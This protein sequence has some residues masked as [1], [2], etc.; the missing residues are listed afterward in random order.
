M[1]RLDSES[2]LIGTLHVFVAFDWGEEVDLVK[3]R[4][5]VTAEYEVLA[6]R[7]RTPSSIAYRPAPLRFALGHLPIQ[8]P[9]IGSL[10]AEVDATLFD[11]AAISAA[12]KIPFRLTPAQLTRVAAWLADPA[13]FC[14]LLRS[15]LTPLYQQLKPAIVKHEWREEIS[16]EYLVFEFPLNPQMRPEPLL[17]FE[18]PWL[19]SLVTLESTP[20][21]GEEI[22]DA[23]RL[24]ISYSPDDLLLADWGAAV[25]VDEN[26]EETLQVIELSNMQLLEYRHLD[27]RLD[28]ILADAY[29]HTTP[30]SHLW[31]MP[32]RMFHRPLRKLG[33]LKVDANEVFER[34]GNVLKLVGDQYLARAYRQLA[35]RF[36][37]KEWEQSIHRKLD[38]I[39]SIYRTLSDQAAT[40]RAELME[41]IIIILIVIEVLNT[42]WGKH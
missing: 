15:A 24:H 19:A 5:L 8:L 3:A 40:S 10:L 20:L 41:L 42:F 32:W 28:D 6:R 37:L 27:N 30:S 22:D 9:E 29:K 17:A 21:S 34:T 35:K 12:L 14:L 26:C 16:E 18:A 25:L 31:E 4:S 39:E 11:F 33:E 7:P 23:V 1:E 13:P 2:P 38:L 36:H